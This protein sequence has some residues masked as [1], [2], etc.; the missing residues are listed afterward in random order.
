MFV[1]PFMSKE[2]SQNSRRQTLKTYEL[3]SVIKPNIDSDEAD[4]IIAKVEEIVVSLGGSVKE[5]DK[6]G[7][8]KLSYDIQNFRDGYFVTQKLDLDPSKVVE[9]KRQLKLTE[10]ILRIM[11]L[12]ISKVKV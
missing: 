12:E 8:K 4:K 1:L 11:F 3:L 10:S 6:M 5:T 9:F 7:R 2:V